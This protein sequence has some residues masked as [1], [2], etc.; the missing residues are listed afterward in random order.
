MAAQQAAGFG[1]AD[2]ARMAIEQLLADG[3]FHQ[4]DLPRNGGGRQA[5]AAGHF[6]KA[7]LVQHGHKQA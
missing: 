5:F 4:V 3:L 2:G 7:A 6:R 1:G